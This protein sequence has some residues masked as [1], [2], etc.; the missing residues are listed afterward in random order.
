MKQLWRAKGIFDEEGVSDPGKAIPSFKMARLMSLFLCGNDSQVEQIMPMVRRAVAGEGIDVMAVKEMLRKNISLYDEYAPE[1]DRAIRWV[2]VMLGCQEAPRPFVEHNVVPLSLHPKYKNRFEGIPCAKELYATLSDKPQLP[3]DVAFSALISRIAPYLSFRQI[4]YILQARKP[5]HWR[6]SDIRRLRYV[7]SIKKKVL[8]ISESYGGLSFMPQ[9]FF[10]SVFLGEATRASLRARNETNYIN[11]SKQSSTCGMKRVSSTL[12]TLR[13]RRSQGLNTYGQMSSENL[14]SINIL[15]PAGRLASEVRKPK[16]STSRTIRAGASRSRDTEFSSDFQETFMV[17]DSL[18]GPADVAILLQAGLTSS[19]KGSTVVQLNQRMLLDLMASQP[20]IFA[21][22]VLAE[23]GNEGNTRGLTSALMALLDFDQS[24]FSEFHRLD[25]H[26]LLESWLPGLTIP[27]RGDY[28][29]GGRWAS[30]SYYSAIFGVA[31]SIIDEAEVYLAF[32]GHVQRVRHNK[33]SDTVPTAK[34]LKKPMSDTQLSF[35]DD[36]IDQNLDSI[37][38]T[39]NPKLSSA[40]INARTKIEEADS[41]GQRVLISLQQ[42]EN[43]SQ[44]TICSE[45]IQKYREAFCACVQILQLDRLA[46]HSEWF[47]QFYRRNYDALMIKSVYDNVMHNADDVREWLG[48]LRVARNMNNHD[49]SNENDNGVV[50]NAK[51]SDKKLYFDHPENLHEQE[52]IHEIID[53]IFFDESE[54]EKLRSDPLVRLLISNDPGNYDFTIVSA[55]GVI[56]EGKKGTELDTAFER[57]K[58]QRNVDVVRADT[59]TARS[60]E[61]NASRIEDAIDI[62]VNMNKPYGIL[63]Y[64]QGCANGL[65][66]ESLLNSGTPLQQSRLNATNSKLVCRQLLF[67]AAN[68]SMHGPAMESKIHR[69]VVI[70]IFHTDMIIYLSSS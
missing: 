19:M 44:S 58:Q 41:A 30:Q 66:C 70:T 7:Y 5:S 13:Q 54:Q 56:T 46:F 47:K 1:I 32:K 35:D 26:L 45:S 27:R 16:S 49:D 14:S 53:L 12:Q 34:E 64:S 21:V 8:D 69:Y 33:E 60:F 24:S 15:S 43:T 11:V 4:E 18:L 48:R 3:L 63:G 50:N 17:G 62:A 55:M 39:L 23:I 57:L 38:S 37:L 36:D 29:A 25:I 59:G 2:E 65:F 9:S 40:I 22:A 61:F 52:I 51:H 42:K 10:V 6:T 31:E 67:S 28:L 20:R 68:G